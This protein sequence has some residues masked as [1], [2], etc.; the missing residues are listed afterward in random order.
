MRPRLTLSV[1]V[2][3]YTLPAILAYPED[4]FEPLNC[5]SCPPGEYLNQDTLNCTTCP[6]GSTTFT[7]TNA[8]SSLDC[9]CQAGFENLTDSV[10]CTACEPG[11]YKDSIANVSC[12][13]CLPHSETVTSGSDHVEDCLC[14]PGYTKTDASDHDELC[15]PCAAGKFKD[16][17]GDNACEECWANHYCPVGI[18]TPQACP[19]NRSSAAG[20]SVVEDCLCDSGYHITRF[21]GNEYGCVECQ[22]GTYNN[23][24]NQTSCFPCP[25]NTYNPATTSISIDACLACDPNSA[26]A[27]GSTSLSDCQCNLGYSGSPGTTCVACESGTYRED[28]NSYICEPCPS[29]T[30]N[31]DFAA[32]SH[33]HCLPCG[34]NTTSAPGSRSKQACVCEEG[35]SGT[36]QYSDTGNY[37]ECT[38]CEAG[39]YNPSINSTSCDLCTPGKFS[40][41]VAS[42]SESSC[43][44]LY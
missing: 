34:A 5:V 3:M 41:S 6:P 14:H 7:Y 13:A 35:F 36:L 23:Q 28:V 20:S 38:P 42:T 24:V 17:L 16:S 30:Y 26:S 4:S 39:S 10:L 8:S 12:S 9:V 32:D 1:C 22:A 37:Y 25:E 33:E 19:F 18:K 43:L 29:R 27:Q 2:L 15:V 40:T 11:F 44:H 31:V 21:P